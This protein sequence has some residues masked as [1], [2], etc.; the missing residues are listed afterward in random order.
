MWEGSGKWDG[1]G[2]DGG[3]RNGIE[4]GRGGEGE[5]E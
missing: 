5:G 2:R 3:G 1:M 4:E